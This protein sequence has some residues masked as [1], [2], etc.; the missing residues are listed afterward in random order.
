VRL[1]TPGRPLAPC[2]GPQPARGQVV[3]PVSLTAKIALR[4]GFPGTMRTIWKRGQKHG[5]YHPGIPCAWARRIAGEVRVSM[6]ELQVRIA[7]GDVCKTV[8]SAYVGS[9]PTPATRQD[10]RSQTVSATRTP[11]FWQ[12]C[13]TPSPRRD[14]GTSPLVS[15]AGREPGWREYWLARRIR[16]EV[17]AHMIGRQPNRGPATQVRRPGPGLG[18]A[19]SEAE[20]SSRPLAAR[21]GQHSARSAAGM[22]SGCQQSSP[23]RFGRTCSAAPLFP[24]GVPAGPAWLLL[25]STTADRNLAHC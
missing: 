12:R 3:R 16:G 2:S 25:A 9:N 8:G 13:A 5:P 4:A 24:R 10:R 17:S 6:V 20:R 23:F 7:I 19:V 18:L 1:K 21:S 15:A 14:A 22:R 11:R